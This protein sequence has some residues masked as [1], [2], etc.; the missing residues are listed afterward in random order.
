MCPLNVFL[1]FFFLPQTLVSLVT[2]KDQE[3][4]TS[5]PPLQSVQECSIKIA[6][7]LIEY[8]YE[9]NVATALPEPKDEIEFIKAQ[10]LYD[11]NYSSV[12]PLNKTR[13]NLSL[14]KQYPILSRRAKSKFRH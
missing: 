2:E 13:S 1:T 8:A 12:L 4:R 3:N 7:K 5:Y 9:N 14:F 11:Y 10:L 6:D